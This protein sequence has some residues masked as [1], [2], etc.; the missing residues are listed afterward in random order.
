MAQSQEQQQND[1]KKNDAGSGSKSAGLQS[2]GRVYWNDHH[3]RLAFRGD[4]DLATEATLADKGELICVN[5]HDM[6]GQPAAVV[7]SGGNFLV[8]R[9]SELHYE[10]PK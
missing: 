2:L 8:I 6:D 3:P 7:A 1:D 9:L 10:Q 4:L 5:T